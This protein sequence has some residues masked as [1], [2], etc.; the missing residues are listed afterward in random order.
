[1]YNITTG[2]S[3]SLNLSFDR[4]DVRSRHFFLS[5]AVHNSAVPVIRR[6]HN[7]DLWC[8]GWSNYD[9]VSPLSSPRPT[10]SRLCASTAPQRYKARFL[11]DFRRRERAW[12]CVK[13]D[14]KHALCAHNTLYH[15]HH[16]SHHPSGPTLYLN[17]GTQC[18]QCARETPRLRT[19]GRAC[20]PPQGPDPDRGPGMRPRGGL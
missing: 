17:Y 5:G 18:L 10:Q 2:G 13:R 1:M 3:D 7:D 14:N 19:V 11:R 9:H 6:A 15:V 4:P 12:S 8:F 20:A 16:T